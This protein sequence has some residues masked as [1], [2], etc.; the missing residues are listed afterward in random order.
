MGPE[1]IVP[2]AGM[3]TGI[4]VVTSALKYAAQKNRYRAEAMSG[5]GDVQRLTSIVENLTKE[6]EKLRD[7]VAVL[8]KLVTDDDRKLADEID[9]LRRSESRPA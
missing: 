8:E 3:I 7:R 4:I 1:I 2:L 9:R 6:T 5:G